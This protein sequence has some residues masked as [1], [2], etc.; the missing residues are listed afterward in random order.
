MDQCFAPWNPSGDRG[1]GNRLGQAN[2]LGV[3]CRRLNAGKTPLQ[4]VGSLDQLHPHA[5]ND[6]RRGEHPPDAGKRRGRIRC[7]GGQILA[8]G[9]EGCPQGLVILLH[10]P[11]SLDEGGHQPDGREGLLLRGRDGKSLENGIVQSVQRI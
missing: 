10:T 11:A 9:I 3:G 5:A 7:Q 1:S 6:E 4:A 8:R 2:F